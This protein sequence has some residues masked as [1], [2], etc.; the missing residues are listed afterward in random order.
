[1]HESIVRTEE[2]ILNH[3]YFLNSL[4][5]SNNEEIQK[6]NKL[7]CLHLLSYLRDN[8][9]PNEFLSPLLPTYSERDK[10]EKLMVDICLWLIGKFNN[11]PTYNPLR[12]LQFS[13]EQV[14][15]D[16][17]KTNYTEFTIG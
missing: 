8:K 13:V 1:M 11:A 10:I 6:I 7:L 4:S 14:I 3:S 12:E 17:G 5:E 15:E 2:D 9:D 16:F